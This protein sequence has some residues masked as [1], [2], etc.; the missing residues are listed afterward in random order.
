M[1]VEIL[2]AVVNTIADNVRAHAVIDVGA[3]QVW[4]HFLLLTFFTVMMLNLALLGKL[5]DIIW[6]EVVIFF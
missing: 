3:G 6:L 4:L 2:S 5:R 1:Q